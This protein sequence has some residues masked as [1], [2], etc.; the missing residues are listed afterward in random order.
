MEELDALK[1]KLAR[2]RKARQQ[3]ETILEEKSRELYLAHRELERTTTKLKEELSEHQ[4]LAVELGEKEAKLGRSQ[5]RLSS[6]MNSVMDAVISFDGDGVLQTYNRAAERI[7]GFSVTEMIGQK[8]EIL[9]P[10]PHRGDV[11][12]AIRTYLETRDPG[13]IGVTREVEGRRKDGSHFPMEMAITEMDLAES[14]M[15]VGIYRDIT[16]R[17]ECCCHVVDAVRAPGREGDV[18]GGDSEVARSGLTSGDPR[19]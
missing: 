19:A 10:E 2:E 15:F 6:I 5:Q 12:T 9:L 11:A 17:K 8:A 14:D 7:F 13:L 16:R 1:S 18:L 3:A 4:R